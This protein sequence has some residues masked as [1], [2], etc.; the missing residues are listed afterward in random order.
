MIGAANP[1]NLYTCLEMSQLRKKRYSVVKY[2][3][4]AEDNAHIQARLSGAGPSA[5]FTGSAL[6]GIIFTG[7]AKLI[8]A[9]S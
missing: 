3:L 5:S 7:R 2:P 1:C 4:H 9:M 8:N 6:L